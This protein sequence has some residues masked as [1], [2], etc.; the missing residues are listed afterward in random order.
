MDDRVWRRWL[1]FCKRA[2]LASDPFLLALLD[3]ERELI[4]RAFLG[5]YKHAAWDKHGKLTGRRSAVV[6]GTVRTAAS[7]LAAAF[8]NHIQ[9]S[10]FHLPGS[11][12]MRPTLRALLRAYDNADPAPKRQKCITPKLLR[13]LFQSTGLATTTLRD[14]APA[15]MA[16]ITIA[17]FFF[18]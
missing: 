16:D 13:F 10:P 3:D 11:A 9:H 8:R 6:A 14:S 4:I 12:N 15:V 18:A 7:S 1:S 5:L 17:G 2:G